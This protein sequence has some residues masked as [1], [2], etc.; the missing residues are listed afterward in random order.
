MSK[1]NDGQRRFVGANRCYI[2][3]PELV[4]DLVTVDEG[5][6][7]RIGALAQRFGNH[8]Q[9]LTF[10]E[11]TAAMY[12]LYREFN[13]DRIECAHMYGED[14]DELG[15]LEDPADIALEL[16]SLYEQRAKFVYIH[17]SGT[18][19]VPASTMGFMEQVKALIASEM[20]S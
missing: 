15:L 8:V 10:A 11:D 3:T 5:L 20:N 19:E 7:R 17:V 12:E 13:A 9:V 6:A 1:D 2:D 16:Q 14:V 4:T 18:P